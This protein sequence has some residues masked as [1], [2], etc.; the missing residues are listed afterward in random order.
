MSNGAIQIATITPEQIGLL[1]KQIADLLRPPPDYGVINYQFKENVGV[2]VPGGGAVKTIATQNAT[3]V[4]LMF[5]C[6]AANTG[7]I[8]STLN[9]PGNSQGV[10]LPT[11]GTLLIFTRADHFNL[12]TSAWFA[13]AP[14][15]GGSLTTWE[16][17]ETPLSVGNLDRMLSQSQEVPE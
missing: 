4:C 7:I 5:G 13:A 3:R 2:S 14:G 6:T 11:S 10:I 16:V 1:A 12:C 15:I 8:V 9:N 17:L